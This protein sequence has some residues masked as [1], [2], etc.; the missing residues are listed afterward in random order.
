MSARIVVDDRDGGLVLPKR[1]VTEISLIDGREQGRRVGKEPP[2]ILA[3]EY[4]GGAADRHDQVRLGTIDE[5]G[6]DV[7]DHRWFRRA[8]KPCRTHHDL[9][10][11]DGRF[12]TLVQFDA[13]VASELVDRQVAA[14][15]RLQQQYLT[16]ERL[17]FARRRAAQQQERQRRTLESDK[18]PR[19]LRS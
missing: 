5:G 12:G 7:V 3:R 10:E 1:G 19:H 13:E 18:N 11:V 6:S 9:D 17:R 15:D 8:D 2:P 4:R 16:R 14:V